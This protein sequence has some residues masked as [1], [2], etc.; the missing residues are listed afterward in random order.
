[1]VPFNNILVVGV[2]LIGGSMALALKERGFAGEIVGYGRTQANLDEA[3]VMGVIDR[4]AAD[5]TTA[6]AE[7]DLV[8]VAVP[9]QAS[10]A[11]FSQVK[12]SLQS[13]AVVTDVG[14]TKKSIVD[15]ARQTLGNHFQRFVPGHPIAGSEKS[16][17]VSANSNLFVNRHVILTPH[18]DNAADTIDRVTALWRHTGASVS[19]LPAEYHDQVLAATS[20]L[21][22]LLAYGLVSTLA[23]QPGH[24]DIFKYAAGG[25]R[26]FTRIASS[27]PVMWRDICLDNKTAIQSILDHFRDTLDQLSEFMANDDG[28]ALYDVFTAA[29]A[30]RDQLINKI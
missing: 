27:D 20:H 10:A 28:D 4:A 1:M 15:V 17:A 13:D 21:P 5:L 16:G 2:G 26:D 25:F 11:V 30:Q 6:A 29:K 14:S 9:V 7:A 24:E 3:L 22:H 19:R 23:Q 18:E 12:G 8:V